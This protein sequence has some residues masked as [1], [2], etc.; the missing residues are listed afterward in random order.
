MKRVSLVEM[1]MKSGVLL[2][3][4][5]GK[6]RKKLSPL[7]RGVFITPFIALTSLTIS[8]GRTPQG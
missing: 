5:L 7:P 8:R 6:A 4:A 2:V 1:L 3:S